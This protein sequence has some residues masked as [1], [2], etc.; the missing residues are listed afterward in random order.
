MNAV[1][2]IG[3][4]LA[5][6]M[7]NPPKAVTD[8]FAK[9]YPNIKAHWEAGKN[10]VWEADFKKDQQN[11][12]ALFRADGTFIGEEKEISINDLPQAVRA[13]LVGVTVKEAELFTLADGT[14]LYEVAGKKAGQEFEG[15]FTPDGNPAQNPEFAK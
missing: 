11:A 5:L 3:F 7:S 10:N 13:K 1:L 6:L 14:K 9:R 2:W 4:A 8:A 15:F 12:E